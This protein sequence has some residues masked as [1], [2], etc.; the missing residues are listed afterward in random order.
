MARTVEDPG[1]LQIRRH[2]AAD[3]KASADAVKELTADKE[4]SSPNPAIR[5]LKPKVTEI[6]I[7]Y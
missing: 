5:E 3:T 4:Y 7:G 1:R 2:F 6:L